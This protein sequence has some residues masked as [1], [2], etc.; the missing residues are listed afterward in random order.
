MSS[1][2]HIVGTQKRRSFRTLLLA[3]SIEP[4]EIGER[5]RAARERRGWTQMVFANEANVS[6]SS[7]QRWESGALP[8]IRE[9]IRLAGVLG[10]DPENLVEVAPNSDELVVA[11]L[12]A[13][14]EKVELLGEG[15]EQALRALAKDVRALKPQPKQ[16]SP[17]AKRKAAR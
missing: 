5:L 1:M 12:A 10:I 9:L 7:V 8:P 15:M 14:E 13:L 11:R 3:V 16:A 4:Q 17:P 2:S 6:M